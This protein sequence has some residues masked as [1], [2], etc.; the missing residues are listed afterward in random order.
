MTDES[1]EAI[2]FFSILLVVFAMFLF[3][4]FFD[5]VRKNFVRCICCGHKASYH[6][7]K[8]YKQEERVNQNSLGYLDTEHRWCKCPLSV[9]MVLLNRNWVRAGNL[10]SLQEMIAANDAVNWSEW[11]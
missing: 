8:C 4:V 9:E 3:Y 1:R 2:I 7:I 6:N 5:D 10:D 11:Q